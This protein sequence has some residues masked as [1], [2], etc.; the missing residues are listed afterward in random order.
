MFEAVDPPRG[1]LGRGLQGSGLKPLNWKSEPTTIGWSDVTLTDADT[2]GPPGGLSCGICHV[3]IF[4]CA[5]A[6][7]SVEPPACPG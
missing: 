6:K 3:T 2:L 5:D 1:Y 4:V 7:A